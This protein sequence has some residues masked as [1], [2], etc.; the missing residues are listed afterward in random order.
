MGGINDYASLLVMLEAIEANPEAFSHGALVGA[1]LRA[2]QAIQRLTDGP[3]PRMCDIDF[4]DAFHCRSDKCR[5]HGQCFG[6]TL[7]EL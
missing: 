4:V 5:K 7:E 6:T 1:C 3:A 2:R